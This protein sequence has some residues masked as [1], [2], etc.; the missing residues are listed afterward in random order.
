MK[1]SWNP[2]TKVER[3]TRD[4][5]NSGITF[6][7]N[8]LGGLLELQM[9]SGTEYALKIPATGKP[10]GIIPIAARIDPNGA[11]VRIADYG[12]N[13]DCTVP[14]CVGLTVTTSS[15]TAILVRLA[16]VGG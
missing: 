14:G 11:W 2:A 9:T 1:P 3:E 5:L 7:D 10:I 4:I 13:P 6:K 16:L 12:Y 8:M 15:G